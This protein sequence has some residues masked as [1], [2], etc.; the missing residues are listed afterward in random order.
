VILLEAI[1]AGLMLVLIGVIAY[2]TREYKKV[3]GL[4]GHLE[5]LVTTYTAAFTAVSNAISSL[6]TRYTMT[7][8]EHVGI[9]EELIAIRTI[10]EIHNR[11]L[12]LNSNLLSVGKKD[13]DNSYS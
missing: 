12:N 7:A 3:I 1:L 4:T 9:E 10:I 5:T 8:K 2:E 11:A 6:E 13:S